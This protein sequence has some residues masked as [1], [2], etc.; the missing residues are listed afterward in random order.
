MNFPILIITS[1]IFSAIGVIDFYDKRNK[2]HYLVNVFLYTS[3]FIAVLFVVFVSQNITNGTA[4]SL[5]PIGII[6]AAFVASASVMKNIAVTRENEAI[7]H[8][9]DE[10]KSEKEKDRK[11]IFAL[12]VMKT[13]QVTLGTFS[14][15]T[16]SHFRTDFDS[17][18]Q[19]TGKLLNSVFCES[20]LPYLTEEEQIIVSNFY[21]EYYRFLA[22][23]E[24][25]T[26]KQSYVVS[27]RIPIKKPQKPLPQ[28]VKIF[29][30]FV[31]SYIDLN[32]QKKES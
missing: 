11:R 5:A 21:S 15:K 25:N 13:I 30:D 23:Y 28:Y 12:N 14:K 3:W 10:E 4:T 19:T 24:D 6:I 18:I 8:Q 2:T 9:K 22:T 31:Q 27:G 1:I 26:T 20:I 16:E 7:K 17:D 32:I 29:S